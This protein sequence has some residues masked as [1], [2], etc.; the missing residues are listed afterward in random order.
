MRLFACPA[1]CDL[2]T[3]WP[4]PYP[5]YCTSRAKVKSLKKLKIWFARLRY[6]NVQLSRKR[7]FSSIK[8]A[9][10]QHCKWLSQFRTPAKK[11]VL[12]LS[13]FPMQKAYQKSWKFAINNRDII[14]SY[15]KHSEHIK[16]SNINGVQSHI[17][18][19]IVNECGSMVAIA[20][21]AT[22]INTLK[23]SNYTKYT[24]YAK[25]THGGRNRKQKAPCRH[26][27]GC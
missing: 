4:R 21:I 14:N 23:Y 5:W 20:T 15:N 24:Y 3:Y 16:H 10:W 26:R 1:G 8:S 6:D 19:G 18:T 7:Q 2:L 27:C 9:L 17:T 22:H 25:Y 12:A 13:Q 11:Q